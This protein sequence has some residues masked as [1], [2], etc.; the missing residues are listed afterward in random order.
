MNNDETDYRTIF[1]VCSRIYNTFYIPRYLG[2]I[3]LM[4]G[5]MLYE[6]KVDMRI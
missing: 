3:G 4:R 5:L 2:G 6:K 1:S